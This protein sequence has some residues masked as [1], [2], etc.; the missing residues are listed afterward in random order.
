[1]NARL[2][3]NLDE[4]MTRSLADG[5]IY[6]TLN[7]DWVATGQLVNAGDAGHWKKA[8]GYWLSNANCANWKRARVTLQ[9]ELNSAE[10]TLKEA[11]ARLVGLEDVVVL[12]NEAIGREERVA[13]ARELTATGLAQ[14]IERAERHL[15]VVA[16]DTARLEAERRDVEERR[17]KALH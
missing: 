1:M 12:L 7:G 17:L 6:V 10:Q 5:E 13:M 3:A 9:S 14:E 11:R 8:R 15:R 2:A 16:D 4:A